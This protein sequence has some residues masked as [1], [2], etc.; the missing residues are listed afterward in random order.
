MTIGLDI[1]IKQVEVEGKNIIL[2]IWDLAG[3]KR[4]RFFLPGYSLGASAGIFMYD[5]TRP[6]SL[7]DIEEWLKVFKPFPNEPDRKV[8]IIMVGGK[9]DMEDRRVIMRDE[10]FLMAK[11]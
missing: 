8:P 2:Q 6:T 9:S 11:K 5:V 4:F 7:C 3:E 1:G 10:G